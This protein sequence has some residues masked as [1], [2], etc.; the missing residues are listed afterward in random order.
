MPRPLEDAVIRSGGIGLSTVTGTD[1]DHHLEQSSP[2]LYVIFM[3]R[4]DILT[5]FLGVLV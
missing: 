1:Q 2:D 3:Y 5:H 4:R